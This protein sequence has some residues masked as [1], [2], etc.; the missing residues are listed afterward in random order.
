[1]GQLQSTTNVW[2]TVSPLIDKTVQR[3][4]EIH[5]QN[6]PKNNNQNDWLG[7]Y[8]TD[9]MDDSHAIYKVM[10]DQR[11][12]GD[13]LT[14]IQFPYRNFPTGK[15]TQECLG[16]YVAYVH[17]NLIFAKNCM[18]NNPFWMEN[19]LPIIGDRPLTALVIPGTHDSG[20]Y[21]KYDPKTKDVLKGF[22][23]TQDESLYNQLVYGIRYLDLRVGYYNVTDSDV[24]GGGGGRG[25][26]SDKLWIVHDLYRTDVTLRSAL[27]QI[28]EFLE[29]APKEIVIVDFHRFVNGFTDEKDV[30]ILKSRFREWFDL[31]S[32]QL[33][34]L[35]IPFSLGYG[36]TVNELIRQNKRVLV[37]FDMN[38]RKYLFSELLWPNVRHQWAQTDS[39]D[40]LVKYFDR[41]L[42][43]DN[44]H[45][46]RS[47][48][49]ELTP[50]IEGIIKLKYK[51]LRSLAQLTNSRYGQWFG[52]RWPGQC[53]NVVA[54][55][56]FL[57]TNIV[58][59]ALDLNR[60]TGR[61]SNRFFP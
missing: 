56:F 34:D 25:G 48:M 6:A 52:Q 32:G 59:L 33:R 58:E 31:V 24:D 22:V 21:E 46:L 45:T 17:N 4:L 44:R 11:I 5:W 55:D 41:T 3:Q 16:Y 37:G 14:N 7:I 40:Q 49:A 9:P 1:M 27:E 28:R 35:M 57:S 26:D 36:V 13:N 54:S 38:S 30:D 10:V 19:N 39:M 8:T 12:N 50:T 18:K 47:A 61:Y 15:L 42:C 20:S 53:L 2:L 29:S 60:R 23:I 51:S 43:P